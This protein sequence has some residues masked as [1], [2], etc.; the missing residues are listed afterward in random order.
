MDVATASTVPATKVLAS[1]ATT[2]TATTSTVPATKAPPA[3]INTDF[4][5]FLKMLTTQL[6]NQD[7]LKPMDSTDLSV[8]LA[9]FSGVEQQVQTNDL[10]TQMNNSM[11]AGSMAQFASWVGMEARV[12]AP[13]AYTG[14]PITVMPNP[15]SLA[16]S[17][18][19]VVTDSGGTEVQRLAIDT[20][21][22]PFTW[23]GLNDQ[24]IPLPD[25]NYSFSVDSFAN[26]AFLS[27][28]S[29]EI[30][31]PVTEVR[32]AGGVATLVLDGGTEVATDAVTA[33]RT[34]G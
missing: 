25:G 24:G 3:A 5:T 14:S 1:T 29:A 15:A 11:A 2:S 10:L 16:E 17:A 13:A 34:P 7:P 8:Q 12:S 9:T 23:T 22:Q 18:Q 32:V 31:A 6:K 33:L 21:D 20:T 28:S 19:L 4:D 27:T 26:G 30:Y